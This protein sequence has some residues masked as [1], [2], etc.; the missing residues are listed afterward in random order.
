M[1]SCLA[2]TQK[3][4]KKSRSA[5]LEFQDFPGI[6]MVCH[7]LCLS[8]DFPGLE[9]WRIKFHNSPGSVQTLQNNSILLFHSSFVWCSA[10]TWHQFTSW[11]SH[12]NGCQ[13]SLRSC[14][15]HVRLLI[16]YEN[17]S[18]LKYQI[19]RHNWMHVVRSHELWWQLWTVEILIIELI[20]SPYHLLVFKTN[21]LNWSVQM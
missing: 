5:A 3:R 21:N 15:S 4:N 8:R 13:E 17:F 7:D 2:T 9:F 19:T 10:S 11:S 14:I 1:P 16:P 18:Q 20:L 12:N 6:S